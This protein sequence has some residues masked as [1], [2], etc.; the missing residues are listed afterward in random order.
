VKI[1]I[2]RSLVPADS[3]DGHT[4]YFISWFDTPEGSDQI[5]VFLDIQVE[6]SLLVVLELWVVNCFLRNA[7]T[8]PH[9]NTFN[10]ETWLITKHQ[11]SC[12]TVLAEIVESLE[13]TIAEIVGD[14]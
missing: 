11:V 3:L 10:F 2:I 7:S 12:E 6:L 14:I 13:E 9:P 4:V 1:I 8:A 5:L